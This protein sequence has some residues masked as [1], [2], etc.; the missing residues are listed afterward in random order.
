MLQEFDETFENKMYINNENKKPIKKMFSKKLLKLKKKGE[1]FQKKL[2]KIINLKEKK[3]FR[4]IKN[5]K[6]NVFK[7]KWLLSSYNSPKPGL[8]RLKPRRDHKMAFG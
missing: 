8:I 6:K 7:K 4:K 5:L 1:P 3:V 2:K